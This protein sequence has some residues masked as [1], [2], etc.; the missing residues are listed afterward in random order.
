MVPEVLTGPMPLTCAVICHCDPHHECY[1]RFDVWL[2]W[3][4]FIYWLQTDGPG[5]TATRDH[6][7]VQ[8]R[9]ILEHNNDG[10]MAI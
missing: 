3:R 5:R 2:D 6:F 4:D 1:R 8:H 9:Y 10:I 7:A